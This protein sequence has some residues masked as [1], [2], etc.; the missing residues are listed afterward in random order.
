MEAKRFDAALSQTSDP[1]ALV[2]R[3]WALEAEF[4]HPL[5]EACLA[6]GDT[7]VPALIRQLEASLDAA[8][9]GWPPVYATELLGTIGDSRAIP[10]LL[11]C[12]GQSDALDALHHE[13]TE[14]LV[15]LGAP[16]LERCLEA[17]AEA[18]GGA[19]RDD[20]ACVL[21]RFGTQDERI[22]AVLLDTLTRT[23]ELGANCLAAYGDARAISALGQCFDALPV[24][25]EASPLT[26]R[27]FL[28][29][30]CA[31]EDLGGALTAEQEA[32]FEQSELQRRRFVARM[33]E[34]LR[35]ASPPFQRGISASVSA[36]VTQRPVGRTQPKLGRNAPCWCGS[37]K[38]Y[39]KCHL[40]REE[41]L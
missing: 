29:L 7:L 3:L 2:Q 25:Q 28:E 23:P 18:P 14:A 10:V 1:W 38:K 35:G 12:L 41:R 31:I 32:K 15:K 19:L 24:R 33:D 37:G 26:N 4:P 8:A 9:P 36:P 39:K 5:R 40:P 34:A 20:L 21:E 22:Y 6:V 30:R 13:A 27:V 16:A 11:R 17:Y